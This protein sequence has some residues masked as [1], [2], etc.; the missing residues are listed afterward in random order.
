MLETMHPDEWVEPLHKCHSF[1]Y[2]KITSKI[3]CNFLYF[4]QLILLSMRKYIPIITIQC[5]TTGE[6]FIHKLVT[7]D[8]IAVTSYQRVEVRKQWY[9]S[10]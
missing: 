6:E 1:I 10:V 4:L 9:S 5:H 3:L 8:F 2:F 7:C